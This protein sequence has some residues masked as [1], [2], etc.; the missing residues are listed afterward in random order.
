MI[1]TIGREQA[2]VIEDR[3]EWP[4]V[5]PQWRT[6][7]GEERGIMLR[8]LSMRDRMAALSAATRRDGSVDALKQ[9]VEEVRLGISKPADVP[10]SVVESW[11][12]NVV[13]EIHA[14]LIEI[15]AYAPAK[16]EAELARIARDNGV[17]PEDSAD[18]GE[19]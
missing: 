6:A 18:A 3:T 19:N 2:S 10:A 11:N 1:K 8:A 15:A 14:R 5:V 7:D 4:H 13:L 9:I 16:V 12:A 17:E